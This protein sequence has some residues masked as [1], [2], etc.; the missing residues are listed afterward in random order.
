MKKVLSLL[1][2]GVMLLALSACA[3]GPVPPDSSQ[4]EPVPTKEAEPMMCGLYSVNFISNRAAFWKACGIE[5]L[6]LVALG[7]D[8]SGSEED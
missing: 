1:A 6:Q 7:M 4:Q 3:G 8:H 5:T 2:A